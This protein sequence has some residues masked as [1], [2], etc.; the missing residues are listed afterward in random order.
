MS[1][2]KLIGPPVLLQDWDNEAEE[3]AAK[4]WELF[5]D[6]LMVAAASAVADG[7]KENP[8]LQG[9]NDFIVLYL[10]FVNAWMLYTNLTTRFE[11]STFLHSMILFVFILGNA[12][13]I[14]NAN[15]EDN[16]RPLAMGALLQRV[17]VMIMLLSVY[18]CIPRARQYV[19]CVGLV[20]ALEIAVLLFIIVLGE[21]SAK[22]LFWV[23]VL[24]ELATEFSMTFALIG[25]S[26]VPINIEHVK[27]RLGVLLLVMLGETVISSTIEYRRLVE[28]E[29]IHDYGDYYWVLGWAL[30]IVFFYTLLYFAMSPPPALH[31]F[32]RSRN[33][34]CLLLICHKFM[35][36][37]V[38]AVGVAVKLTI[39]AVI[40]QEES[41]S[42]FAVRLWSASVGFSLTFLF[43]LRLLHYLGVFPRGTEPP[44]AI[45]LMKIWWTFLGIVSLLPFMGIWIEIRSPVQSIAFYACYLFVVCFVESAFTHVLE[46]F[47]K[48]D[49]ST[50]SSTS[51]ETMPFH[52]S[53]ELHT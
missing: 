33:H 15:I 25:T 6:L 22:G 23:A 30:V 26:L 29:E 53:H 9:V 8:T 5:L 24:I 51:Q 28:A 19:R 46:P 11:D 35:C 40:N 43:C 34:G 13:C 21:Q 44:H 50:A 3:G 14:V 7:L 47:L 16:S 18:L 41:L 38:L 37:S 42:D 1:G 27:D 36:G 45:L 39:E 20:T 32:R 10:L 31:G 49:A 17:A 2:R 4:Y 52:K 12:I 48:E